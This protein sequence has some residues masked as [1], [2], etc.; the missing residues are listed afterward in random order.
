MERISPRP[1]FRVIFI[2]IGYSLTLAGLK[3]WMSGLAMSAAVRSDGWNNLADSL[4]SIL[5]GIGIT[6]G[7]QPS[8]ESHPHGHRR[9]ESMVG[10]AVGLVIIA[11]GVYILLECRRRWLENLPPNLSVGIIAGLIALMLSKIW[12][13]RLCTQTADRYHRPALAAVGKDQ[14]MDIFATL[15][16]LI[17]YGGG[18]WWS[19]VFD[20]VFGGVISLWVFKVG[21]ETVYEHVNQ[22]TGKSAPPEILSA[23]AGA[24]EESSVLFEMND[25]R[26][27]HVGP[28]YQVSFNVFADKTLTLEAVHTAEEEL[29]ARILGIPGVAAVFIHIEPY[30][31]LIKNQVRK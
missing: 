27:H 23:I 15:S 11:T 26:T 8:D 24:V 31:C 4:Y 30:D 14:Q 13:S 22:L 21:G 25:L 17:G 5:L 3:F 16:A 19:P 6:V 29:K 1:I 10:M 18:V 12:M 9:F 2:L 20:P 7:A 28:E